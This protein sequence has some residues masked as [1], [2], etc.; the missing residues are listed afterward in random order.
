MCGIVGIGSVE[1]TL[2]RRWLTAANNI[3]AHRG[4]DGQ[5]E[6]WSSDGKVGLFHRRLSIVDLSPLGHQPMQLFDAGLTVIFNGEIYN[7][8]ELRNELKNLGHVFRSNSD[9]EVLLAAYA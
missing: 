4:P 6:Y 7:Y 1:P 3:L 2:D 9:T 5:G 8:I